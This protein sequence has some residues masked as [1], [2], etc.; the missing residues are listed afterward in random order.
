[1]TTLSPEHLQMLTKGSG[2]SEE[3][4]KERGYY[5]AT[6]KGQ[7]EALGFADF[8]RCAPALVLPVHDVH[9]NVHLHQI[10]P[11]TPRKN[12]RGRSL[13]YDTPHNSH[14]VLDVLPT[15]RPS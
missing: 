1:M 12:K 4:I 9:G 7:L 14:I 8:Q 13:K 11:D 15:H 6:T 2:I 5:T 10:R 3:V